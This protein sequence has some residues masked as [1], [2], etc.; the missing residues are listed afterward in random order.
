MAVENLI[1]RENQSRSQGCN[2]CEANVA[3]TWLVDL[4]LFFQH[5]GLTADQGVAGYCASYAHGM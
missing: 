2:K 1:G 5:E 4:F 3:A